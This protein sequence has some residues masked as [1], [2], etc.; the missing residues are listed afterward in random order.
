MPQ[1]GIIFSNFKCPRLANAYTFLC[2]VAWS[3]GRHR[4]LGRQRRRSS[5]AALCAHA[6]L[7]RVALSI[8]VWPR[9]AFIYGPF[10]Y[11][12]PSVRDDWSDP[13]I[14]ALNCR[15]LQ[16]PIAI[17][18]HRQREHRLHCLSSN[19]CFIGQIKHGCC[20]RTNAALYCTLVP[21]RMRSHF[22]H[23]FN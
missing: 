23:Q 5:V 13:W 20:L 22:H 16:H 10:G 6:I 7:S 17:T 9:C 11:K 4:A 14:L 18:K 19:R 3:A 8:C 12:C 2:T 1:C 15:Q 21:Y